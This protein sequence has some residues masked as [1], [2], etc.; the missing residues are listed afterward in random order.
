M[1]ERLPLPS[2]HAQHGARH[3]QAPWGV[4]PPFRA[5]IRQRQVWG[6]R[7][8]KGSIS[9]HSRPLDHAIASFGYHKPHTDMSY[10]MNEFITDLQ[11]PAQTASERT[12]TPAHAQVGQPLHLAVTFIERGKNLCSAV[13]NRVR[14]KAS[15]ADAEL[16]QNPYPGVLVGI[17]AGALLAL[18]VAS[19]FAGRSG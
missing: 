17:G 18:L 14:G 9:P 1:T 8:G 5:V 4:S 10:P 3:P 19:R 15:A 12:P 11:K 6:G 2:F 16:H 13:C 7:V